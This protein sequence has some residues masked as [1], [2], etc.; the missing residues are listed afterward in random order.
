MPREIQTSVGTCTD[1]PDDHPDLER[2]HQQR[3]VAD[4]TA[5]VG[6]FC[7]PTTLGFVLEPVT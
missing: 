6:A 1:A 2:R 7:F 5:A 4:I 3:A